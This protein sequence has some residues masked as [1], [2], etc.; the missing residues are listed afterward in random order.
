MFS[1]GEFLKNVILG[2]TPGAE[3][4]V[5][6]R[7][8]QRRAAPAGSSEQVPS[9]G[10]FWAVPEHSLQIIERVYEDTMLSRCLEWPMASNTLSLPGIDEQSRKDGQRWGGVRGYWMNEADSF[11]DS[12]PKFRRVDLAAKKLGVLC[13]L[14]EELANDANALEVF[15]VS[16]FSRELGFKLIDAA[17]NGDGSGK[18]QGILNSGALITVNK[19]QNQAPG[20]LLGQNVV[21]MYQ[22][23]WGPSRSR[24][25]WLVHSDAVSQLI[26]ATIAVGTSGGSELPLYHPTKD[27]DNQPFATMLG[28]PVIP[29]EQ[30]QA[31]GS[32]GDIILADLGS[33]ILAL[34]ERARQDISMELRF[35]Y[36][37]FALRLICRADGQS[38]WHTPVT[39]YSGSNTQSPFVALQTRS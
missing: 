32:V 9:E 35:L 14:T 8:L 38:L 37:E 2:G 23:C 18:P 25:V 17:V 28:C 22:R 30:A 3:H 36:D 15:A 11:K 12:K 19:Q 10:G 6:P 39:P 31:V 27:P 34:R 13:F 26:T 33:Y 29:I 21:D 16:A 7:L 4:R 1:F 20:T 24:A 5:D